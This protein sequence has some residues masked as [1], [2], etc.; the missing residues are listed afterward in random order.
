MLSQLPLVIRV[1]E[2]SSF[3]NFV[4]GDNSAIVDLLMRV[5]EGNSEPAVYVWGGTSGG[6][7]HLLHAVFKRTQEHKRRVVY[8]P[9]ATLSTDFSPAILEQF[10]A[11]DIVCIDDVQSIAGIDD[12][13][14]ALFAFYN[15]IRDAGG[16]L[17]VAARFPPRQLG[18]HLADL[19]S[20][21]GNAVVW[22]LRPLNDDQKL[23]VLQQCAAQQGLLLDVEVGRYMLRHWVRDLPSLLR[24][25]ERLDY[26]SLSRQRRLTVPF[27]REVM[28]QDRAGWV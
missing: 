2:Q 20:R 14:A 11:L 27:V 8:L 6:K 4:A 10:E 12:W 18:L 19:T 1:D 25:F 28:E 17:V 15:R 24:L 7:T 26:A 21:L 13:E 9:L 3:A 5:S 23:I 22:R 16:A